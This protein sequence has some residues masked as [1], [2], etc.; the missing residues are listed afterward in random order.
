LA[1]TTRRP[2]NSFNGI[3][4]AALNK[5]NGSRRSFISSHGFIEFD[6]S[7]YH[8]HL[9]GRM[10]AFDFGDVD[11]HQTFADLYQTSYKEAKELTFKQLYG[12]VF[13]EYEHLE[14]FQKVK[15]FIYNTWD[16]FNNSGQTSV[17]VSGYCFKKSELENMNPQKLF[18]YMLQN[19]ESAMNVCILMDI[20]KLLRGRK[21]KIVLYTYDS[22]LFELGEGEENIENEIKQIFNKYK[23]QTK[24]SYGKTYDFTG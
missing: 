18:N 15:Q 2:S 1:T 5:D 20:H 13:K 22:F 17:P 3:N 9:A 23:L 24:T 7:A 14:F 4:F 6:I 16:E 8:P 10:V 12:G 19:L 21:T 11:V